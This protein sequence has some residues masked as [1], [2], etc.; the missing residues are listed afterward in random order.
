MSWYYN[1][2][3]GANSDSAGLEFVPMVWGETAV[4]EVKGASAKWNGVTHV[5][6]FNE[7]EYSYIRERAELMRQR[8]WEVM[9]AGPTSLPL[10]LLLCTRSGLPIWVVN[11]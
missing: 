9:L 8:I 11:T 7:R 5:L 10:R 4:A 2:A 6:G 1:W 3:V